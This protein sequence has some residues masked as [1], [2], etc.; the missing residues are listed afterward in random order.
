MHS[1]LSSAQV[2]T[3]LSLLRRHWAL[4]HQLTVVVALAALKN[5]EPGRIAMSF[6]RCLQN[7]LSGFLG[8]AATMAHC[9]TYSRH[10]ICPAGYRNTSSTL[11]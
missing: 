11:T 7:C 5:P 4:I 9:A 6:T 8:R 10:W 3:C 1:P 2:P